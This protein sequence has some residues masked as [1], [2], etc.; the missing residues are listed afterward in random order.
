[1]IDKTHFIRYLDAD[2]QM[3]KYLCPK[4]DLFYW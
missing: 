4:K 1:M 3:R 2:L